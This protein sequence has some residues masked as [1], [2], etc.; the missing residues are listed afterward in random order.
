VKAVNLVP[1]ESRRSGVSVRPSVGP[2]FGVVVLLAVALGFVTLY[3]VTTNSIS[4]RKA[5]L[6][7]VQ[8]QIAQQQ[9]IASRLTA[10]A[11][12]EKLAQKRSDDIRQVATSRFDWH[13]ALANIA[14]VFPAQASLSTLFGNVSSTTAISGGSGSSIGG[15]AASLR[16]ASP[17]PAVEMSGCTKTQEDVA[18]LMS[19]LR[20]VPGV[21]RVT[22][23]DS[24]KNSGTSD[25]TTADCGS[26]PTFDLVVFF[27][28]PPGSTPALGT[29][30]SGTATS[31]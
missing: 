9:A 31:P 14:R 1:S 27:D 30:A 5:K 16:N 23:G 12:F 17:G 29:P 22:L 13:E 18:N 2:G 28:A 25:S 24:V 6:A 8:S 15:S 10:Y 3:V 20:V 19:R 7:Q 21:S 11:T 4:D 26:G